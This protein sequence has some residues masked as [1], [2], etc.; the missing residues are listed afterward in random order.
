MARFDV[1]RLVDGG[2]VID[3]QADFLDDIGTRFVV[4]LVPPGESPPDNPRLNP[5]FAVNGEMLV[6]VTQLASTL[7]T[8]ELRSRVVSLDHEHVR[9]I[10]AI[11][12]LTG[13][14]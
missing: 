12:V 9:I 8:V 2:M 7:R 6:M 3:C 13:S 4:P 11:D 1:H 14:S 10:N 5:R